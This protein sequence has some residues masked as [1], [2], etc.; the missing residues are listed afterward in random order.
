MKT[1]AII[2]IESL[3]SGIP[4]AH[5]IK[6]TRNLRPDILERIDEDLGIVASGSICPGKIIWGEY[7]QGKTHTLKQIEALAKER[8]FAV[9]YV[10]INR[11]LAFA[12]FYDLFE[13]LARGVSIPNS[14]IPG[15]LNSFAQQDFR[16]ADFVSN[17]RHQLIHP[18]PAYILHSMSL[19]SSQEEL[20]VLYS[21]LCGSSKHFSMAKKIVRLHDRLLKTEISSFRVSQHKAAF[22]QFFPQLLKFLGYKGWV[23]LLDELELIGRLGKISRLKSYLN[24]NRL[25]NWGEEKSVGLYCLGAGAKTLQEEVF[26]DKKRNDSEN[27]PLLATERISREAGTA[28]KSFF[29]NAV[30]NY[31]IDLYPVNRSQLN[32]VLEAIYQNYLQVF[33]WESAPSFVSIVESPEFEKLIHDRIRE[34]IRGFIEFLDSLRLYGFADD[35]TISEVNEEYDLEEGSEAE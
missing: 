1:D 17:I 30:K 4:S 21:A 7:G 28:L 6:G 25:L 32:S 31:K 35:L 34:G 9:S 22:V 10:S 33:D 26:F 18:L 11:E 24:L 20:L 2:T 8:N 23:I 16:S 3:R 19:V 13:R 27:I 5:S 29:P 15:L 14:N 12:N